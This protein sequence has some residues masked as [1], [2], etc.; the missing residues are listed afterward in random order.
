[1]AEAGKEAGTLK[2]TLVDTMQSIAGEAKDA[3]AAVDLIGNA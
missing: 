1:M 2:K 3:A